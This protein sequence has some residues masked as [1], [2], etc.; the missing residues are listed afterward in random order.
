MIE[1]VKQIIGNKGPGGNGGGIAYKAPD[2]II[3]VNSKRAVVAG[4][5]YQDFPTA[6][7]YA[8]TLSP[9]ISNIIGIKI[10]GPI[11]AISMS[12]YIHVIG[13]PGIT[14][15]SSVSSAIS[16]AG[17]NI[18]ECV[19]RGCNITSLSLTGTAPFIIAF[20]GNILN[21]G[22]IASGAYLISLGNS[23]N[24]AH[25]ISTGDFSN[26]AAVILND[27]GI[28]SGTYPASLIADNCL[29]GAGAS[30]VLNG[31]TAYGLNTES[32]ANPTLNAGTYNFYSGRYTITNNTL[33]TGVIF[34][35]RSTIFSASVSFTVNG[36]AIYQGIGTTG[37]APGLS[38]AGTILSFHTDSGAAPDT[39]QGYMVNSVQVVG[40][41]G[42]AVADATGA[43]DVVAQLNALLARA[44]AH[45]LIDT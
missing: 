36:G 18:E 3:Q 41:Q 14:T 19:I 38:G 45:G 27:M 33:V 12:S 28:L 13:E 31:L 35:F 5:S 40:P 4:E 22:T 30:P 15:V 1:S 24:N 11:G 39:N 10:S 37:S 21:A 44:R 25:K 7:A 2:K 23:G 42:A 8:L 26:C 6:K 17:T 32:A 29:F 9:S 20:N 43:G 34:K 16:F